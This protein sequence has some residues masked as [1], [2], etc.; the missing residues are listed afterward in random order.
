MQGHLNH[1]NKQSFIVLI[2]LYLGEYMDCGQCMGTFLAWDQRMLQQLTDGMRCR[3]PV[4]LT[5]KFACDTAVVTLMRARTTGNTPT[6]MRNN[7]HELHSEEWLKKQLAYLAECQ[8]HQRGLASLFSTQ[9]TTYDQPASFSRFPTPRWFLAVYV[10]DVWSRRDTL[11][12]EATS[13]HGN[14]LKIDSTKKITK[15]LQGAAV[16]SAMW[17]TNVGN[18]RGEILISVL[19]S[20]ES[21]S[22]LQP[23]ASGLVSWYQAHNQPPPK[24]LYTDRDCCSQLGQSK[25]EKL[26][27]WDICVCLDIWHFMRRLASGC[28][29]E[30]HP[31]YDQF[32]SRLSA[33]IFEWDDSDVQLL[34]SAKR[35]EL[36]AAGLSSVTDGST[37]KAISKDELGSHCKRRTRGA[38][39][40]KATTEDLLLSFSSATDSLGVPLLKPEMESIWKEQ[41]K[42]VKCIQDPPGVALYTRTGYSKKGGVSLPVYRCARG[43]TSLESFHSHLVNF[44]PG[45][46]ASAVNFQAYVLDGVTRWNS[47]MTAAA[48]QQE[49]SPLNHLRTFDTRLQHKV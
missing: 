34:I 30:S 37:R 25:Y 8:Q 39:E 41:Q 44:I 28:S 12:A 36:L 35:K 10:R 19:T 9:A 43:S 26:F 45:T 24:L 15:K 31:L 48:V 32:M 16:G 21:I 46:S 33:C 13:V 14:I 22:A 40:T 47:A 49:P 6:A 1:T 11:L 27:S 18:E 7:L 29:T 20:S 42:H 23:L 4:I 17:M 3:F 2:Y 38:E 5:H